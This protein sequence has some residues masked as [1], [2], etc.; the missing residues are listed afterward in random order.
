M[1]HDYSLLKIKPSKDKKADAYY[2]YE[3][4]RLVS[5]ESSSIWSKYFKRDS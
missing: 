2:I 1:H 4:N 3:P 5:G